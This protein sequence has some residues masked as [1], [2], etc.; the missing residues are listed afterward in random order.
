M[1]KYSNEGTDRLDGVFD[2]MANSKRRGIVYS[3]SFRPSTV[4]QLAVEHELSLPAIHKHIRIL[5]A[6]DLIQSRKVGRVNFVA[7]NRQGLQQ[8]QTW[9]MQFHTEWGSQ[10][11]TLENYIASMEKRRT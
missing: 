4:S 5:E 10:H 6:A 8:M 3:L 9:V 2:A 7:L 1:V 11:E